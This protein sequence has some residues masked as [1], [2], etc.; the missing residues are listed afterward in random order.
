METDK[1]LYR[2]FGVQPD[3]VFELAGLPPVGKCVMRSFTVKSLER[4]TDGVIVP[5]AP[6]QPLWVIEFQFGDNPHIYTRTV[7]KMAA[8]QE[9]F[10]MREVQGI[11]FFGEAGLDPQTKPWTSLVRSIVLVDELRHL[12][13]RAPEHPLVAVFQPLLAGRET[14]LEHTAGGFYRTIKNSKLKKDIK[15][16][17]E[18][19]FVS[20]LLQRL[21]DRS[22]KEIEKMLIGELPELVDTRAGQDILRIG[23]ERGVKIGEERGLVE[24]AVILLESKR[25]RLTKS[26][27]QR[28]QTLGAKQLRQLLADA[29]P[30]E[31]LDLLD[32]WLA[33]HG[34]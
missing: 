5:D 32:A 27:R 34:K 4:R 18:E 2:V 7:Q 1:Q 8:I 31:S 33:A 9:E 16:A 10:G 21:P 25:G 23:E 22:K 26:L 15:E 28:L 12:A 20:W 19:V 13:E 14:D 24:A 3:W 29:I 17:L 30:W 11:I 6:F